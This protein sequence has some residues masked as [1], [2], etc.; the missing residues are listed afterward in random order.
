MYAILSLDGCCCTAWVPVVGLALFLRH[1]SGRRGAQALAV[2]L[3][4]GAL[5]PLLVGILG[6]MNG[7]S[8]TDAAVSA[9]APEMIEEVRMVGYAESEHPFRFGMFSTMGLLCLGLVPLAL[10]VQPERHPPDEE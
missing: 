3:A 6:R 5:T 10:A 2:M 4:L 7:R 9:V 1:G 8:A